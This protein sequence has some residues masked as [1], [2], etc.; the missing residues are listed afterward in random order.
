MSFLCRS[1]F[2][3]FADWEDNS[4]CESVFLVCIA[5]LVGVMLWCHEMVSRDTECVSAV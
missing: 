3:V 4:S 5:S 1:V 2:V